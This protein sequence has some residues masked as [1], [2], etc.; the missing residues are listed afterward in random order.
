MSSIVLLVGRLVIALQMGLLALGAPVK[1]SGPYCWRSLSM[2]IA[3][4][5]H[6]DTFNFDWWYFIGHGSAR[7]VPYKMNGS[8]TILVP[9]NN[10]KF[11]EAFTGMG[12]PFPASD[13]KQVGYANNAIT[14][15]TSEAD[16]TMT[17]GNC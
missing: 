6:G 14:A 7:D 13:L 17:N 15:H 8:T 5:F 10:P 11:Q 1:P 12:P 3:F 4:N 9:I 16:L 2:T